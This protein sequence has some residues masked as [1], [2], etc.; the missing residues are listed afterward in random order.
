MLKVTQGEWLRGVPIPWTVGEDFLTSRLVQSFKV[1]LYGRNIDGVVSA[2][3]ESS[4]KESKKMGP[5]WLGT[6]KEMCE[7]C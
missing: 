1:F 5:A 4:Q 7:T 2:S 3:M 6:L